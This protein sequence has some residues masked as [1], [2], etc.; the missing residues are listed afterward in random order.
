MY[1]CMHYACIC[2]VRDSLG[3]THSSDE[4]SLTPC[5]EKKQNIYPAN[6]LS[7]PRRH[8]A[9]TDARFR[10]MYKQRKLQPGTDKPLIDPQPLNPKLNLGPH[11]YHLTITFALTHR[12]RHMRRETGSQEG[13][14]AL[15]GTSGL[16]LRV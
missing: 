3:D 6:N 2:Q 9:A 4:Y 16:G 7:L 10:Q 15:P 1:A 14:K 8:T 11:L 5:T 13:L 12:K